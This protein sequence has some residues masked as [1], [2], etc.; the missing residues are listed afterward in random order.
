MSFG[1]ALSGLDAAQSDLNVT[2][3]NIANSATTGFKSSTSAFAEL[4]A[5][6]PQGVSNTQI[7]NGVQLQAVEQQ[8]K[9]GDIETTGNSLDMAISGNGFFTVSSNGA[10][11]YTRAGSFQTNANGEVVNDAGQSLQVYPPT[12]SGF[13]TTQRINLVIP[14]G[15]SAPQA[16]TTAGLTFNLPAGS[17][18]PTTTPF[19]P[20]NSNSYNQSTSMTLYDSLGAAHTAT[21]YFVS[22]GGSGWDAYEYI[23]GTLVNPTVAGAPKPVTMAFS[24]SGAL[25]GTTDVAGATNT[26]AVS[27]GSYTPTTGAAAMNVTYNLSSATQYG[28]AFG[29]TS[30]TQN[31][32]TT[33]QLSGISISS[34]GV[35]QANYTNGQSTNL[36]QVAIANFPD[37][38]GLQQVANTNW[39]QTFASGQPVYGVAGGAGFGN[40][41]SGALEQSNVDITQQ[42]VNMIT[43]QRAYQANA[44]M[45]STENAITQTTI[46]IPNQQ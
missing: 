10:D 8:F 24:N 23:D 30:V 35:V 21:M 42:L 11:E 1:I 17:T 29:V 5:V 44:E 14:T 33:G 22:T 37:Q 13:N 16:T 20:A 15:N 4:F 7:G 32:F 6:S 46:N 41:E 19:D 43:A 18:A 3:N 36:G 39:V 45:V 27:F 2:A 40:I 9:Q 31:G 28:N 26:G 12:A 25:T 34:T 38:Q